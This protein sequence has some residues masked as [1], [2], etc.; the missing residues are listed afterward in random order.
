MP[1]GVPVRTLTRT[2]NGAT[3]GL[4]LLTNLT[5]FGFQYFD[6]TTHAVTAPATAPASPQIDIKQVC[7]TYTSSAGY[8]PSGNLSNL[9][10][11]SPLVVLKNKGALQDSTYP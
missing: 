7:M 5:S 8:A 6:S 11:V 3:P 4:L 10:V 9:T 1:L 2:V